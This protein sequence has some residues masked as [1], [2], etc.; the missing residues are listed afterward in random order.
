M[1]VLSEEAAPAEAVVAHDFVEVEE[2]ESE[3]VPVAVVLEE[4]ASVAAA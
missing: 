1:V 2:V 3:E 4:V